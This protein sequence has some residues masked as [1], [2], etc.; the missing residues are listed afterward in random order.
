MNSVFVV[1]ID[2]A[3]GTNVSVHAT[4]TGAMDAVFA[5]VDQEW[6]SEGLLEKEGPID[7]FSTEKAIELYFEEME[8]SET[9][10]VLKEEVGP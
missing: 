2:H 10:D 3:H 6:E 7:N 5:Y 1:I 9:W 8:D 4:E